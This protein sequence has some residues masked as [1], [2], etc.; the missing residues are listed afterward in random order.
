[1]GRRKLPTP[2]KYC[3]RCG[4]RLVRRP[5]ASGYKE[6]LDFFKKRKY[7]SVD[8]A[9]KAL[10]KE[11][12]KLPPS[13]AKNGRQRARNMVPDAPCAICGKSGRTWVHHKD[14]NPLNNSPENFNKIVYELSQETAP[15]KTFLCCLWET[16]QGSRIMFDAFTTT[17]ES[18]EAR[19]E[20]TADVERSVTTAIAIEN[21]PADS[22][23]KLDESGTVQTLTTRM[24]T[25][26]GNV[27]MLAVPT[28]CIQGNCI[29][30]ADTAGCN[31][32]GWT[33]DVCYTL[34]TIDRPAV[35]AIEPGALSRGQG[36]RVWDKCPTLRAKMGDNQPCVVLNDQ[37]GSQ[38]DVSE[39]VVGTLRAEMHGNIPAVTT[40]QKTTGPLMANSHPGSYTGQDAH[41]DM[42]VAG[43]QGKAGAEAS[44]CYG[45]NI[46]PSLVKT[47]E[48]MIA[49]RHS[50]RRLTPLE[51]ERLQGY[52]DGWT[53]IEGASD[54]GRYKALGNSVAIPCVEYVMEGIKEVMEV[55][56]ET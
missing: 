32:K 41:S 42:L 40:Y 52:E 5:L 48:A 33:E 7:C 50:V 19:E 45:E 25:G 10:A 21:H 39:N 47:K 38:M 43:F 31:G 29:D 17:A 15:T 16:S 30:R 34:N 44:I 22:R 35:M 12:M 53:D 2:E 37:G 6:P 8:C 51:C 9:N 46:A 26:G 20:I 28:Y 13:T 27:P 18:G 4:I 24:G 3:E 11:K 14:E 55:T 56:H 49:Q 1:M 23:V 36:E 54:S